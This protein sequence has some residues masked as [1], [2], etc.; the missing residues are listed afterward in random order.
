MISEGLI[1]I[2]KCP[3]H[4]L[5]SG[6]VLCNLSAELKSILCGS[7]INCLIKE[8]K[9]LFLDLFHFVTLRICS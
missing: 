7:V 2:S 1:S 6:L 4:S 8:I 9:I 3:I 5:E